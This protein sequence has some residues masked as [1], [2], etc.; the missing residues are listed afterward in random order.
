MNIQSK[1]SN[2]FMFLLFSYLSNK[3]V[4]QTVLRN[5]TLKYAQN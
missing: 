2:T 4:V 3:L 1:I 5:F